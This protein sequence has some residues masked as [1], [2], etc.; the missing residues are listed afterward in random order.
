[1]EKSSN[2]NSFDCEFCSRKFSKEIYL[3]NHNCEKKRRWFQKDEPHA[4][5]GF[6]AWSR[7][8][9]LNKQFGQK[10][11]FK[12]SY[13][14]FINSRYYTDFMK[15]GI[16]I[17]DLNAI[18]PAKFIDYVIKNNLPIKKWTHDFV[19]EQ[20]VRELTRQETAEN[21][22]ERNILLMNEW[23]M[24]NSEPW[25]EFFRKVNTNQAVSWI[26]SGRISPWVLYNVDSAVQFFERCTPEQLGIIKSCAPP[27][28][29][30]IR[31]NKNAESCAFIRNTLKRNGM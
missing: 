2:I 5:F 29:W 30:K 8:Y 12:N 13:K 4:R 6:I 22:L 27:G 7:F 17:R 25:F 14:N 31:F 18:E 15:F 26:K 11:E 23:S 24:Q 1:M 3:I 28:P 20:Y 21:A 10:K 16:H 19:Y 9:E